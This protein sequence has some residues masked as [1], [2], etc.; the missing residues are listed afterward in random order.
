MALRLLVQHAANAIALGSAY[1]MIALGYTI[2]F[3][4]LGLVNMAHGDLCMLASFLATWGV[5]VWTLPLPASLALAAIITIVAGVT[6]ER[7]A[8]KPL[9]AY[10]VSQLTSAMAISVFLQNFVTVVFSPKHKVFPIPAVLTRVLHIADIAVPV[11]T[12]FIIAACAIL[13]VLLAYVVTRTKFGRA[14]RSISED[15][16]VTQLMGVDIN[17]AISYSFA[18]STAF[19][20]AGGF[21]WA[22]K[23]PKV[24]PLFGVMPGL[25]AFVGAVVGGVGSIPGALLGGFVLGFAEIMFMALAPH[26]SRWRDVFVYVVL[27]LFLLFRPGGLFNVSVREEKV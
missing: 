18:L 22:L 25:K 20:V 27:I 13:L 6:I 8:Y 7:V 10:P 1:G 11:A 4:I 21:M 16:E 5:L 14:M 3:G 9:R 24:Y 2:V 26:L 19:A 17:R 15:P 23:F 12:L